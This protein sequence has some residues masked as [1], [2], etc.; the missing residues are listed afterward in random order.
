MAV[1]RESGKAL[2]DHAVAKRVR[3]LSPVA[4]ALTSDAPILL[5]GESGFDNRRSKSND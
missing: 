2:P 3:G 5:L 1:L 4:L